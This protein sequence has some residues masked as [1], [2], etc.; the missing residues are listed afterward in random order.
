MPPPDPIRRIAGVVVPRAVEMFPIDEVLAEIDLDQL[1]ARIDLNALLARVDLDALLENVDLDALLARVDVDKIV[2]R[3]DVDRL[4]ER[5]DISDVIR[6]AQVDAIVSA[7]AGGILKRMLDLV[8]R[9]LVGL[10]II[11]TR[12]VTRTFRRQVEEPLFEDGSVTGQIAGGASRLAAFI[13]DAVIIWVT[14]T[15]FVAAGY[16]LVSTFVGHSLQPADGNGIWHL[17]GFLLL[18]L[19]YQ[20]LGLVIAGRTIGRAIAGL[21][22][23]SP[24]GEP[25]H[26]MT[27]TR[28]V[29]AYPFSFILGIGLIG[30]VTGRQ[31]RAF[32]DMVAPTLVRYDWGDRPAAMPAPLVS[33]LERTAGLS[34][35]KV[36]SPGWSG[37]EN[38]VSPDGSGG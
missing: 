8:R 27:A 26:P 30:I 20:W 5:M 25:L 12:A 6:R 16:F 23:T 29:I 19:I 15:A 11:M 10:D 33:Y 4:M 3:V 21:R 31:H 34:V 13:I 36:D 1:L 17:V 24:D 2:Q 37:Q 14:V 7:T 38:P 18:I 32:H 28:R 22:V 35:Q 9:Q